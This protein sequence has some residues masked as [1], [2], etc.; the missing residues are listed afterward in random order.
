MIKH[1]HNSY[2]SN[3]PIGD[4]IANGCNMVEFDVIYKLGEILVNHS[5][6]PFNFLTYG[7]LS[8]YLVNFQL[9]LNKE[10]DNYF[11]IELKTGDMWAI[12]AL[13]TILDPYI[14]SKEF[15]IVIGI[16]AHSWLG[17]LEGR[18]EL[19]L[20]IKE[21][22]PDVILY[23]DITEEIKSIDLF[24]KHWYSELFRKFW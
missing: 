24:E 9:Q 3:K 11:Y 15:K 19:M 14:K 7:N 4:A 6:M 20:A 17:K 1:S 10:V 16:A 23:T 22:M 5:W 18:K 2:W 12:N 21:E 8:Q 13:K